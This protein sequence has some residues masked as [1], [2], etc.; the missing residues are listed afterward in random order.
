MKRRMQL[1][2]VALSLMITG[3]VLANGGGYLAGVKS[4]G[5][6]RPANVQEVEM[7]SEKLQIDLMASEA[8]ITLNYTFHN[9]GPSCEV[10]MGFPCAI[11]QD[12]NSEGGAPTSS[13]GT[14]SRAFP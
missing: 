1:F 14:G 12:L 7:V 11:V 10:H 5:P 3:S 8:L 2:G 6:F 13:P 4:T 9:P